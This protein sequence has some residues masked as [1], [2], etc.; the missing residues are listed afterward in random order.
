[1]LIFHVNYENYDNQK[2]HNE[3][4]NLIFSVR[5]FRLRV[6]LTI[7]YAYTSPNTAVDDNYFHPHVLF[8]ALLFY[9]F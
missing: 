3:Y 4:E 7:I 9:V 5:N 2:T 1:M 6:F 8:V